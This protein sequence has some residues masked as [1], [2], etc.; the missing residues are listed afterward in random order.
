MGRIAAL[1]LCAT[2]AGGVLQAE[3]A[4]DLVFRSGSLDG[5]PQGTELRY[6]GEAM[7]EAPDG[8]EWRELAVSL[9]PEDRALVQGLSDEEAPARILGSFPASVGNPIAMVFLEEAVKAISEE[10]G[11]SPFYIRNRIRDAL[12]GPGRVEAVTVA[13]DG[14]TVAA[15]EV[16]LVPFAEDA[17]RAELGAFA[18]LEIRVVVSEAVPGWYHSIRAE[19]PATAT[20]EAFAASLDLVGVGP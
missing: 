19:A 17:H 20:E 4:F 8:E 6:G 5:L 14:G 10:T 16:A 15:T 9:A 3:T 2:L 12:G 18:D 13:W 11:G 1:S 7:P